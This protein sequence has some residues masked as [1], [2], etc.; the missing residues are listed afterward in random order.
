MTNDSL[1]LTAQPQNS[2]GLPPV[3]EPQGTRLSSEQLDQMASQVHLATMNHFNQ[4]SKDAAKQRLSQEPVDLIR[5]DVST[6]AS[7][8]KMEELSKELSYQTE[9]SLMMADEYQRRLQELSVASIPQETALEQ[10]VVNTLSFQE[11]SE[12]QKSTQR[13]A[14]REL[15]IQNFMAELQSEASE[16]FDYFGDFLKVGLG[17]EE[18]NSFLNSAFGDYEEV[19][20]KLQDDLNSTDDPE[21]MRGILKNHKEYL[22]AS[23]FLWNNPDFVANEFA[24]TYNSTRLELQRKE[25]IEGVGSALTAVGIA[26]LAKL[27]FQGLKGIFAQRSAMNKITQEV[28]SEEAKDQL[29]QEIVDGNPELIATSQDELITSTL[30]RRMQLDES[31]SNYP[32]VQRKLIENERLLQYTKENIT[33]ISRLTEEDVLNATRIIADDVKQAFK[34]GTVQGEFFRPDDLAIDFML[35]KQSGGGFTREADAKRAATNLGLTPGTFT[36]QQGDNGWHIKYTAKYDESNFI[37]DGL[38][39]EA[40]NFYQR[41]IGNLDNW[42]NSTV[43]N[44]ARSAEGTIGAL[45]QSLR[46]VYNN[47]WRKLNRKQKRDVARVLELQREH[48]GFFTADRFVAEYQRLTGRIPTEKEILA[49]STYRQFNDFAYD[50]DNKLMFQRALAKG[51]QSVEMDF[52]PGIKMNGKPVID[53]EYVTGQYIYDPV[54]KQTMP[55]NFY[56]V[57]DLKGFEIVEVDP[58]DVRDVLRKEFM[59]TG[60]SRY[61]IMK[62]GGVKYSELNPIQLNYVAGGRRNYN[63]NSAFLKVKVTGKYPTGQVFR[64]KDKAV[65][66]ADTLVEAKDFAMRW[67]EAMGIAKGVKNKVLDPKDVESTFGSLGLS[68]VGIHSVD[69]FIKFMERKGLDYDEP[70]VALGNRERIPSGQSGINVEEFDPEVLVEGM[71]SRFSRRGDDELQN[72]NPLSEHI[73]DPFETTARS[74]NVSTKNAA[75][76]SFKDGSLEQIKHLFG[77]FMD[78]EANA[79]LN[80]YLTAGVK[81]DS[82]H[83]EGTIKAYQD[84]VGYTLGYRNTEELLAERNLTKGIEFISKAFVKRTESGGLFV[85]PIVS[86]IEKGAENI[87]GKVRS[88]IFNLKQ[89]MFNPG[90]FIMQASH[91]PVLATISPKFGTSAL[92]NYPM[93]RTAL[94]G[95]DKRISKELGKI[96]DPELWNAAKFG[97]F[98]EAVQQFRNLGFDNFGGNLALVDAQTA[99]NITGSLPSDVMRAGRVFFEEGERIP[100]VTAF[101]IARGKWIA[102]EGVNPHGLPATSKAGERF[103][104]EETNRL[105]LGLHRSDLQTALRGGVSGIAFQFM[106]Y[107]IRAMQA[108]LPSQLG[109]TKTFTASEKMRM[110]GAY[111]ILYGT[112]GVP[113]ADYLYN[114]IQEKYR[115]THGEPI[116]KETAYKFTNGLYDYMVSSILSEA[117]GKDI[118]TNFSARAGL[119]AFVSDIIKSLTE[120]DTFMEVATGAAGSTGSQALDTFTRILS[121]W[122]T[123]DNP[124]PAKITEASLR[125]VVQSTSSLNNIYKLWLSYNGDQ[126][127]SGKGTPLIQLSTME[128]TLNLLGFPP[129]KYED[130]FTIIQSDKAQKAAIKEMAV[131]FYH[132]NMELMKNDDPV[133][134]ENVLAQI[135]TLASIAEK[136]GILKDVMRSHNSLISSDN[137]YNKIVQEMLLR[138]ELLKQA[139]GTPSSIPSDVVQR[140][141][142]SQASQVEGSN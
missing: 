106:S 12:G 98:D 66:N 103:I 61:I 111:L 131:D 95:A 30:N 130:M 32:E 6:Q 80:R 2:L 88:L 4:I 107:P 43:L 122:S 46:T 51:Y 7:F 1:G 24:N 45:E 72:I 84:Y 94:L 123:F 114:H 85:P 101:M 64:L 21:A 118:N 136:K 96:K 69:D 125:T 120:A 135:N 47:T 99:S 62:K 10:D 3:G 17:V 129:Q 28:G 91:A 117:T 11:L 90:T 109:G 56:K 13:Q 55:P 76:Q 54:A 77:K 19:L 48:P 70:L 41:K 67:N 26:D 29:V 16:D 71:G 100:R 39:N 115:T 38:G 89:G 128:A 141:Q 104:I 8:K 105:Q 139:T 142:S 53:K 87:S 9:N 68:D 86:K 119:G 112:A 37:V 126:L 31:L 33:P 97:E 49:N 116:S 138:G 102:K 137:A 74:L 134:R 40:V 22:I 75:F 35:G 140:V 42:M 110:A 93:F 113:M 44:M 124:N 57:D 20:Q 92:L 59:A 23:Q 65:F 58:N 60:P 108:L 14:V 78:I 79:P 81:S 15:V 121:P 83:M 63:P 132:L 36:L 127:L 52:L 18:L 50:L 34:K 5:N 25:A 27:S 82:K 73:L 133:F